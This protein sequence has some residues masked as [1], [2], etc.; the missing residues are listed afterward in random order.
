[1][2]KPI[3][4]TVTINYVDDIVVREAY[5]SFAQDDQATEDTGF[6]EFGIPDYRIIYMMPDGVTELLEYIKTPASEFIVLGYDL[7]YH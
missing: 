5:I 7:V 4:A 3:G 2:K 6:D 1:M